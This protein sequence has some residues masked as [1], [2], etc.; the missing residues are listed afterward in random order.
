MKLPHCDPLFTKYLEPWYSEDDRKR[1]SFEATRPDILTSGDCR[2]VPVSELS[3]ISED[4]AREARMRVDTMLNSC[5]ND[6]PRYLSVFGDLDEHWIEAFDDYYDRRRI[7][8]VIKNSDPAEFSNDYLVLVCQFGA[9]L[10]HVL[11]V[12]QPRLGWIYNWP[13]WES[14]LVDSRSGT[15]IPPFHW[16]VKKFSEYGVDDGFSAKIDLCI[17]VLEEKRD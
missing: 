11:R 6:W 10:A 8:D 16:A 12:K 13:Y 14:S 15:V 5:R 1:K 3:V 17:E 7:A 9:A 4:G 2:N